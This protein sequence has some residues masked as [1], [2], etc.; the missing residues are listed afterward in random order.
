[1]ASGKLMLKQPGAYTALPVASALG[2]V[3]SGSA[4]NAV[5]KFD[6]NLNTVELNA[7]LTGASVNL[8]LEIEWVYE[9][10][11]QSS[12]PVPVVISKDY[13]QGNEAAPVNAVSFREVQLQKNATHVQWRY[14]G[15]LVWTNLIALDDL[16]GAA[17]VDGG[18]VEFQK[19]TT[20]LQ[21]RYVGGTT[22]TNLVLLDDLKGADGADGSDGAAG[23][24]GKE[25]ELQKGTTHIQWRYV[26]GTTWTNLVLLDDLKGSDGVD[27]SDGAAGADGSEIELQK[28]TTHIQWRYVGGTTWTDLVALDDLKGSDGADGSDGAAGADALWN[29]TGAYNPGLSY[30]VGDVATYL[31]ETW[32]RINSNGGNVGDTPSEG[33]FWTRIAQKGLDGSDGGDGADGADGSEVELQKSATHIQWR[34]VGEATWTDLVALDDLK[35]SDGADGSDGAAGDDG[36]EV[37]LQKGTTHLQWR[38]VGGATWNNLVALDDLKGAAGSDRTIISPTAP[39]NPVPGLRWIHEDQACAYEYLDNTWVELG[40]GGGGTGGVINVKDFGATGN[41]TT[42]DTAAIQAAITAA[43]AGA[44]IYFPKG[45]YKAYLVQVTKDI[46]IFGDGMDVTEFVFGQEYGAKGFNGTFI[47]QSAYFIL[48]GGVEFNIRDATIVDKFGLRA[49]GRFIPQPHPLNTGWPIEAMGI[50]GITR[51]SPVPTNFPDLVNVKNVKF[52]NLAVGIEINAKKLFLCD[53][54][55]ICTYGYAGRGMSLYQLGD[56]PLPG[57]GTGFISG[58]PPSMVLGCFGTAIIKNN[59]FNGLV[60]ETFANANKPANWELYRIATDNFIENQMRQV[61]VDAW[62]TTEDAVHDYSNN[63]V[64]NHGIEGIH[65]YTGDT[66]NQFPQRSS[67]SISNNFIKPFQNNYVNYAQTVNPCIS[68]GGRLPQ[69]KIVGNRIENTYCGISVDAT[70]FSASVVYPLTGNIEISNNVMNGVRTGIN[71][72][73]LSE[74]DIISNNTIFCQSKPNKLAMAILNG[75]GIWPPSAY[76]A[77]QGIYVANCNPFVTNNVV[78]AEYDWAFT[79]TTTNQA[80]NVFTLAATSS[81]LSLPN[82]GIFFVDATKVRWCPITNVSGNVVT[83]DAGFLG[84]QTFA[85]GSNVYFTPYSAFDTAAINIVNNDPTNVPILHQKFYNTTSKGFL[86]DIAATDINGAPGNKSATL[87]NTTL[88]DCKQSNI[89]NNFFFKLGFYQKN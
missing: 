56:G 75:Q 69:T 20:H 82:V 54:Q 17:G 59:Y 78:T 58:D 48:H 30:A 74:R 81:L 80:S 4:A 5:Y 46:T 29:F 25:I 28:G 57:G 85:N 36:S 53:S 45:S 16:K 31:G 12:V 77:L 43:P 84:G 6:L 67:L 21:W 66:V 14:V 50:C 52:L 3:K 13:I 64:V 2:W 71:V 9:N 1:M 70:H 60:D 83:V 88:I 41:G 72:N 89:N 15:D 37:E 8:V 27:G 18:D 79:T 23:D 68:L 87:I 19:G 35:G 7:L 24:D 47:L 34:Y 63:T 86:Y 49:T 40:G 51:D 61:F 55:F 42:D 62:M 22:W 65:F 26:G 33:A 44:A 39:A 73:R 32:Y 38:Y 76:S 10:V 11:T